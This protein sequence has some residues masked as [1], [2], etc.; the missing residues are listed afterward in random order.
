MWNRVICYTELGSVQRTQT[1][2]QGKDMGN[3]IIASIRTVTSTAETGN[4]ME[5]R[6]KNNIP[7]F[8]TLGHQMIN[9]SNLQ[10]GTSCFTAHHRSICAALLKLGHSHCVYVNNR[11]KYS[12]ALLDL[13]IRPPPW[14]C[15]T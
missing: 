11:Q 9:T 13:I 4:C 3:T 12:G 8:L 1:Q 7:Y 5:A 14:M 6:Y 10:P 2:V 15:L